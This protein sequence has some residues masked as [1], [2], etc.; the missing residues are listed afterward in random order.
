MIK[1]IIVIQDFID[2]YHRN[3]YGICVNI[4]VLSDEQDAIRLFL[5]EKH[6]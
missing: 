1:T 5:L 3:I 4:I 6:V 2:I